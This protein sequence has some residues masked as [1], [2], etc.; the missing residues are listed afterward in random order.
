MNNYA[1]IIKLINRKFAIQLLTIF[2][3]YG[4]VFFVT[5]VKLNGHV[6]YVFSLIVGVRQG[7]VLSSLFCAIFIDQLV[8]KVII[9]LKCLWLLYIHCMP[10]YIFLCQ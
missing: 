7:G 9:I 6:N 3:S 10:Q 1:L 5:C 2:L 4:L 8:D